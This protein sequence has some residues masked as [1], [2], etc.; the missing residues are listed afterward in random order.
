[1]KLPTFQTQQGTSMREAYVSPAQVGQ[2]KPRTPETRPLVGVR[3]V[4]GELRL[5]QQKA[6]TAIAIG[7]SVAKIAEVG[8]KIAEADDNMAS[9]AAISE[10]NNRMAQWTTNAKI[11]ANELNE[12]TNQRRWETFSEDFEAESTAL[13]AELRDKHKFSMRSSEQQWSIKTSGVDAAHNENIALFTNER[14]VE[15]AGANYTVAM[16]GATTFAEAQKLTADAVNSGIILEGQGIENMDAWSRGKEYDTALSTIHTK[17]FD[18]LA[19]M[20]RG[21]RDG[22]YSNLSESQRN[23]LSKATLDQ[24]KSLHITAM[25]AAYQR[26]GAEAVAKYLDDVSDGGVDKS[27]TIDALDH[28]EV[29]GT[30]GTRYNQIVS[31]DKANFVAQEGKSYVD[32]FW[33]DGNDYAANY[34]IQYNPAAK[35]EVD[36]S[37]EGIAFSDGFYQSQDAN[38]FIRKGISRGYLPKPFI[39]RWSDDIM[40]GDSLAI[41]DAIQ[42]VVA[43]ERL[44]SGLVDLPPEVQEK[45]D[46]VRSNNYLG[47]DV[48]Q[49]NKEYGAY[50]ARP[51]VER[52][53]DRQN[54][55]DSLSDVGD[56]RGELERVG[57]DLYPDE[58]VFSDSTLGFGGIDVDNQTMRELE[59]SYTRNFQMSKNSDEALRRTY[60]QFRRSHSISHLSG[61]PRY[62]RFAPNKMISR[63]SNMTKDEFNASLMSQHEQ[64]LADINAFRIGL[65]S[66][67]KENTRLVYN[68]NSETPEWVLL[69]QYGQR[70]RH[71]VQEAGK[72][73]RSAAFKFSALS[74]I[75]TNKALARQNDEVFK[76]SA[77]Q[78]EALIS[79][80]N[81]NVRQTNAF[82]KAT[83]RGAG[84]GEEFYV[85]TYGYVDPY[86]RGGEERDFEYR[87]VT[88][89]RVTSQS[90]WD[91]MGAEERAA[92]N[93]DWHKNKNMINEMFRQSGVHDQTLIDLQIARFLFMKGYMKADENGNLELPAGSEKGYVPD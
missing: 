4:Q 76:T 50:Q 22:D 44:S 80:N 64:Q 11:N 72:P 16:A 74:N 18:D 24:T 81:K 54:A 67:T 79:Q 29:V 21:I 63:P 35:K 6:Q 28:K 43:I 31:A 41:R 14:K 69:N 39:A 78:V 10:Y 32:T 75:E 90:K 46:Y 55:E 1:M 70:V 13:K 65:P 23:T 34:E 58:E 85:G 60:E 25:D 84:S 5:G 7:Q 27:Y 36:A 56:L 62:E 89:N 17:S 45:M 92:A 49:I 86:R 38:A 77:Y 48:E 20:S 3:D 8:L 68:R 73:P 33:G 83:G 19:A 47:Q 66:L 87:A 53:L 2:I 51:E 30:L 59:L 52:T 37:S 93:A 42:Q 26:G 61:T 88:T 12:D 40:R 91:S 82:S 57:K 71:P 15:R 9:N